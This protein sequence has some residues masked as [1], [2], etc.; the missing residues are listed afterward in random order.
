MKNL[1]YLLSFAL[2]LTFSVMSF[3][4][5]VGHNLSTASDEIEMYHPKTTTHVASEVVG[6][7]CTVNVDVTLDDGTVISGTIVISDIS[8]I[9]CAAIH[10]ADFFSNAF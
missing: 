3:A 7:D 6:R 9:R 4:G 1:K 8:W 5:D 2:L 10:V